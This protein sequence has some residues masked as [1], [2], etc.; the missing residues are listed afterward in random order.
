MTSPDEAA[1][2]KVVLEFMAA[3]CAWEK[4]ILAEMVRGLHDRRGDGHR[5]LR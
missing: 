5:G 4:G 1:A 2:E 3:M